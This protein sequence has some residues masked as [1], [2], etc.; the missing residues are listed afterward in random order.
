MAAIQGDPGQARE[1]DGISL[2]PVL[3]NP[4]AKLKQRE[5]YWHY[6]H[7]YH[8]TTPVSAI[9]QGD[10]KLLEFFEDGHAELYNLE[11]DIGEKNDLAKKNPAKTTELRN[12]LSQWRKNVGAPMPRSN[13]E[14]HDNKKR[15]K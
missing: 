9:R 7:Y 14:Y 11:G 3:E 4:Q 2:V 1:L 10:W 6:P 5:I 13:P 15:N 8:T 12:L